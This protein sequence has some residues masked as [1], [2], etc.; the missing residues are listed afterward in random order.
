MKIFGMGFNKQHQLPVLLEICPSLSS[1]NI[2]IQ[3]ELFPEDQMS[4]YRL[5]LII[6][7]MRFVYDTV[8]LKEHID[9]WRICIE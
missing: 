4:D 9:V 5:H 8:S 2:H 3:F 1:P 6:Q 7:P